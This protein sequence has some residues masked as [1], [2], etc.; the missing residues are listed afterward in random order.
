ML[1]MKGYIKTAAK[2]LLITVIYIFPWFQ[3]DT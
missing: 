3:S 2:Q 1:F